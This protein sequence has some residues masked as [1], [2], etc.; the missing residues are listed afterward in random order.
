MDLQYLLNEHQQYDGCVS[1]ELY[2]T[3]KQI[4][5]FLPPPDIGNFSVNE[6]ID[7]CVRFQLTTC[8]GSRIDDA[9][10]FYYM[11]SKGLRT[12]KKVPLSDP[13]TVPAIVDQLRRNDY[14]IPQGYWRNPSTRDRVK[15]LT[16]F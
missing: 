12:P 3:R 10:V 9:G 4:T 8:I 7:E 16:A 6:I 15:K 11:N 1:I 14:N 2:G 13:K 5:F